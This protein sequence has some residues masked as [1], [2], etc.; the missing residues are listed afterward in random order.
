LRAIPARSYFGLVLA[1]PDGY[2]STVAIYGIALFWALQ[3]LR[4]AERM[5]G[6]ARGRPS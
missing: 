2:T 4:I 5:A 6:A 3:A 1:Q